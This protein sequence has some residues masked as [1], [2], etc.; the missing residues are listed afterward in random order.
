MTKE[1]AQD[2]PKPEYDFFLYSSLTSIDDSYGY[3]SYYVI[4]V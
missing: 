4:I 3:T 2:G 1:K